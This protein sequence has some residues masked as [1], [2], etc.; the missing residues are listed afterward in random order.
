MITPFTHQKFGNERRGLCKTKR[1]KG[2][3]TM[4]KQVHV[5]VDTGVSPN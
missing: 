4:K 2:S 3:P 1:L 5:V